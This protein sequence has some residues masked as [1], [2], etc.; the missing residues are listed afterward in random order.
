MCLCAHVRWNEH[1]AAGLRP[2]N[3]ADDTQGCNSGTSES[4]RRD[5]VYGFHTSPHA[6]TFQME[7]PMQTGSAASKRE[8]LRL[9]SALFEIS[10][11]SGSMSTDIM[12]LS[13]HTSH[14]YGN[15]QSV[16]KKYYGMFREKSQSRT[17]DEI[18]T[19]SSSLCVS[20]P[21]TSSNEIIKV[22]NFQGNQPTYGVFSGYS[23]YDMTLKLSSYSPF[24]KMKEKKNVYTYIYTT[25]VHH[26]RFQYLNITHITYIYKM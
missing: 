16:I 12:F 17:W 6:F 4:W 20:A 13:K 8:D 10:L 5:W 2:D 22:Q 1:Q 18:I 21:R 25:A 15:I 14:V 7:L 23:T 19:L 9:I 26:L 11:T 3:R 24:E